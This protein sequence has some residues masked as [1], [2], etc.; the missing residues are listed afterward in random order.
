MIKL[1]AALALSLASV[2]TEAMTYTSNVHNGHLAV[3]ATGDIEEG[4]DDRF[5]AFL[6]TLPQDMMGQK[7][8]FVFFNSLGGLV[9]VALRIAHTVE[10]NHFMTGSLNKC[11]SACVLAWAVGERKYANEGDCIGVHSASM[12]A[13]KKGMPKALVERTSASIEGT[14]NTTMSV[15][16][17]DHGA[18]GIVT[19]KIFH[20]PSSSIYCLTP[21]DLAA[22]SVKVMPQ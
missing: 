12:D 11:Q 3:I 9:T 20:T 22:W 13:A 2:P 4:D 8:N 7:G 6:K 19:T 1:A 10:R 5:E 14:Y 15:W 17:W 18:P 21:D 16:L